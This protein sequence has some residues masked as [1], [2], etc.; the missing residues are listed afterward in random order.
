MFKTLKVVKRLVEIGADMD[1][2]MKYV[3]TY[4]TEKGIDINAPA[5]NKEEVMKDFQNW[6]Q[7]RI[8]NEIQ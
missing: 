7:E 5:Y 6:L 4:C 2:Y 3:N 8:M 1:E